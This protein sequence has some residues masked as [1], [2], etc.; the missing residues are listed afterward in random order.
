MI[1]NIQNIFIHKYTYDKL[2]R[3]FLLSLLILIILLGFFQNNVFATTGVPKIINHQGRLLDSSGSLLG[4]S[5]TDYC[6]KF[7]IYDDATVGGGDT[8]LWPASTPSIMTIVVK[9]G[10]FN[11]GV[12]DTS[13]GGDTL[14]FNFQDN[15]AVYLN[16]EVATKVGGSCTTGG[17]ETFENLGPRQRINSSGYAVNADTVDGFHAGQ[18]ATGSQ[19]VALTSGNIILGGTNPQLNMTGS[20]T[21]TFQ[22]GAGT[23]DIQFFSSSNKI[24]SAGALTIAGLFTANGGISL[25]TQALTGT[26]GIINYTNF[27]V[28]AT[29]DITVSASKG[30]DTN[31]SG[32]LQIAKTNATSLDLCNSAACDTI[33]IG[34]LATTDADVITIGDVLDTTSINST[35]WSITGAGTLAVASASSSGA[36]AANGGI[37]FDAGTD[38]V[39][40]HTMG[41]NVIGGGFIITDIGNTG[42]DFVASTGAL[43][44]A[45]ILT[46]NGGISLAGSQSLAAAALSY[47]DLGSIVHNTT[48]IQGLRLPQAASATP[49]SPTSGEGYLAW[50]TAGNQLITY[51]GSAWATV[52]GG[53]GARL[54][55]ITAANTGPTTIANGTNVVT[56]N[57]ALAATGNTGFTFGETTAASSGGTVLKVNTLATSTASPLTVISNGTANIL[58]NLAST[59]D[60]VI[61][62]NGTQAFSV[63]DTGA[64]QIGVGSGTATPG[65]LVLDSKN[66]TGDPTGTNG[67]MYYNSNDLKFR[68]YRNSAWENCGARQDVMS[69]TNQADP[70]APAADT[71]SL[72]AKKIA[73]KMFLKWKGPSGL[74]TPIQGAFWQNNITMWN[75]TT[76]TAG[77]WLGTAGAGAGTYTT[78][79]PT[80][81][82][83]YTAMKRGRWAN[84]VT[85]ANQVLGQRNTEAM[86]FRGSVAGQG[87]FFF[88]ARLG[89]DVWTNGGRFFAGFHSATTVVSADP[90]ALNNTMGF[91]VDAADNGAISFLTRG[92]AATKASTGFTIATRKGYD[93]F[94]FAPPNDTNIYWRIIDI[95]AATEASG[96]AT[97]NLP[98]NT[99]LL[100]AGVLAS[101]AA[102]TP[103]TSIQLGL[104]KIYIETDY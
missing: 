56:W 91:A 1:K 13:A 51:N 37:T 97:A 62:D 102:L 10:V 29:G 54:D 68:C 82:S 66:T 79:L 45:G 38:T 90:S 63:L 19:V 93:V 65:L 83:L 30:L 49:S 2:F 23:G 50:D 85:T 4:G 104:N 46:A 20:N 88:Y 48:A 39:G 27:D 96:T 12:G 87:G 78:A 86:Y 14:D 32:A 25:A 94:I 99:T 15:D 55:Q 26:T 22:G 74:E 43:T 18:S 8:K 71:L 35:G 101:N 95:N 57:W 9:R 53:S 6:F 16:V 67:G 34:N 31:A 70:S 17:D 3:I 75:P 80:T 81:T 84:V 44:L 5:G 21:L 89:F 103:V 73:G 52:G 59:G 42:T 28:D 72:Y 40:A 41:G 61:Q 7:S 77:V 58:F 69:L 60:F 92:T 33:S 11:V 47:I 76:A 36:I 100:T 98:T 64:V 24:T